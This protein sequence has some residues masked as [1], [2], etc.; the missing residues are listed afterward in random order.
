[1]DKENNQYI[2]LLFGYKVIVYSVEEI[3]INYIKKSS[4]ILTI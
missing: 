3:V 2:F 4:L 1:M